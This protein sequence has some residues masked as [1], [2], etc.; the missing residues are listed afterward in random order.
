MANYVGYLIE[1]IDVLYGVG[2]SIAY[3]PTAEE[4]VFPQTYG[5]FW[6]ER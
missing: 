4:T 6:P 5:V 2:T 1:D 3:D